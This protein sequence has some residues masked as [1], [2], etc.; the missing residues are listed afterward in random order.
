MAGDER[1]RHCSLCELHVYNFAEMTRDEIRELLM[2][3]NGRVCARMYRRADG[4]LLTR[5]CPSMLKTARR[6]ISR[7]GSAVMAAL[8][9]LS[10]LAAGCATSRPKKETPGMSLGHERSSNP[11][12][13]VFL[14]VVRDGETGAVLP[15]VTV[16]LRDEKSGSE[17]HAVTDANGV[18]SIECPGGA[19]SVEVRLEGFQGAFVDKLE[20]KQSEIVRA[21]VVLQPGDGGTIGVITTTEQWTGD[22][23]STTFPQ[24]FIE[25]LPI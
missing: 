22:G 5:D 24:S 8:L 14:G 16:L 6:R 25:K 17:R 2:R 15:G 10:S 13:A 23:V 19:C 9:S 7:F 21:N 20:M 3:S 12:Q 1:I 18:F 4:T 11:L